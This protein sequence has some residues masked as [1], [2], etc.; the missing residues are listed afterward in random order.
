VTAR[1]WRKSSAT[2]FK[3]PRAISGYSSQISSCRFQRGPMPVVQGQVGP[4]MVF[5]KYWLLADTVS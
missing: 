1:P 5:Y 3:A 2:S 4:S